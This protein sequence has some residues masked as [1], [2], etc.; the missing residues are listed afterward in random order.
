MS[1]A[2]LLIADDDDRLRRGIAMRLNAD[3]YDVIEAADGAEALALART[4]LPDILILDV[5][6]PAGDGLT[7]LDRLDASATLGAIPA[8]Y[9]SGDHA[10]WLRQAV[11]KRGAAALVHKPFTAGDLIEAIRLLSGEMPTAR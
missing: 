7:V 8:I 3:G 6:M 11:E 1:I 9:I 5:H 10:P 2:K 4:E